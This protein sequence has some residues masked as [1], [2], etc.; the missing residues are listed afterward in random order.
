MQSNPVS[1]GSNMIEFGRSRNGMEKLTFGMIGG[2]NGAFIGD[3]HRHGAL[4][5]DLAQLVAGCF[6]RNYE[7]SLETAK[8]WNVNK[9]RVYKDYKEM[10]EKEAAREDGIDFVVIATPNNTH[11]PIAKCFLEHNIHVMCDKLLA[12]RAE[13]GYELKKIAEDRGLLFGVSYTFTGYAMIRQAYEMIK[14]GEIGNITCIQGE[15][16]QEWLAVSL[17][18]GNS[19]QATWRQDPNISGKSGC[20]ADIGT[21]VECLISKMTGLHPTKVI[22][23]F[24]HIPKEIPLETNAMVMCEFEGGV[25]GMIWSS[26][27]AIGNEISLSAR[28]YGDKGSIEWSHL[29]PWELKY[30]KVNKPPQIYT[31]SRDYIYPAAKELSRLPSGHWEAHYEAFGNIYR[32]FCMNLLANKNGT[33]PGTFTFPDINDGIRGIEFIDACCESNENNNRWAKVGA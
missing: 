23:R 24:D 18:S 10:A 31:N 14:A 16:P 22:A 17:A 5:D 11:Y 25:P 12:L 7:K 26:Q 2:G 3:V 20:L 13:E 8:K 32:G 1:E 29:R 6:T 28:I 15:F 19:E 4:I 21:H 30:T 33:D 9:E 27:I